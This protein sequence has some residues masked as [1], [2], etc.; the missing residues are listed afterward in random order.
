MS[1][2]ALI[3]VLFTAAYFFSYFYRSANAVIA[4]D[5]ASEMG[6]D[7]AQLGLMTSLFYAAF[8]AM[9]LPLGVGLDRWGARWVTSGLMLVTVAGSL[10]FASAGGFGMLALGRALMGAGMAG[11]L[12]GSLKMFSQWFSSRRFATV[13]GLLVGIGS[14]GALG[15]ATPLA[16]LNETVGWRA[17]FFFGGVAT[18]LLAAA[19]ALWSRNAPPGAQW[20]R[21]EGSLTGL[22]DVFGNAQIW[23]ILPLIFF[24]TGAFLGFQGLWGGPY[25]YDVLGLN[26]IQAG[27]ALLG[28]G[29]AATVGFMVSGWLCDRFGL[30]RMVFL[31]AALFVLSQIALALR[32]SLGF[33]LALYVVFGFAG[34]F[35]VML[36]AHARQLFPLS[37]VGKAVTVANLFGISGVFLL[38]WWLGLI[39][40]AFPV[41]F[42]GR[43]PPAAYTAALL[44][45]AGGIGLTLLWYAPLAW[46]G[47]VGRAA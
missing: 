13:S 28:L 4:P 31:A 45:S 10:V 38:Q 20:E 47:R 32:P 12:M 18:A 16:W 29:L 22:K 43:Y 23:R 42:A 24:F 44:F 21:G 37:M 8:A 19:I 1:K 25:L 9:Q 6:L 17:V 33:T 40:A 15:A 34:A 35:N 3:F 2:R 27:N 36:L 30:P 26:Q 14:L 46:G 7:A 11:V 39:I 41:D 5:L